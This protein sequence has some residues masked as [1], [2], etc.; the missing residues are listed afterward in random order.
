MSTPG[1]LAY[2]TAI[3]GRIPPPNMTLSLLA[4][5]DPTFSTNSDEIGLAGSEWDGSV[6]VFVHA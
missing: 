2:R 5:K 6:C 1:L 3:S 4:S